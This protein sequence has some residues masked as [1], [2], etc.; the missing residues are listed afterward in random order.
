MA[1][2]IGPTPGQ[3]LVGRRTAPHPTTCHLKYDSEGSA[4]YGVNEPVTSA[5]VVIPR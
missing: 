1:K 2:G 3:V 4:A 5:K